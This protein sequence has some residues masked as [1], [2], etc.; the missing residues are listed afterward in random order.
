MGSTGLKTHRWRLV[1]AALA[2]VAALGVAACGGDDEEAA[3]P[4][5]PAEPG[6]PAEPPAEPAEPPAEPAEPP[7]ETG[8]PAESGEAPP[9]SDSVI[10]YV[11]YVGGPRGAADPSLATAAGRREHHDLIDS[12]LGAWCAERSG[13][14]I[15]ELLWPA[16][17]P[18]AKAVQPHRQAESPQLAHRGFFED[19]AHPVNPTVR[20]STLPVR[21]THGPSR[22]H[23]RPAP[24]LGEHNHELLRELGFTEAEVAALEADGVIG[25][26]LG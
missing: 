14:E 15:V 7:A 8:E 3:A 20:H 1:V 21:S 10:D 25:N 17:I 6:E 5:P 26:A 9:A 12:R 19:V 22:C 23:R 24:L 13:D 11:A 2:A 18:V 16:G 4:P